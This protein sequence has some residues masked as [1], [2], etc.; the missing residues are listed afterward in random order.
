MF[1]PVV[2]GETQTAYQ[3]Y[4][5]DSEANIVSGAPAEFVRCR[6]CGAEQQV[7]KLHG[8]LIHVYTFLG[9]LSVE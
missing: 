3:A 9:F 1:F 2:G 4:N 8:C 5:G 7:C 6:H